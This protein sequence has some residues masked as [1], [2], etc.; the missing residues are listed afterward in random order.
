MGTHPETMLE[1]IDAA[2][3]RLLRTVRGFTDDDVRRPSLLPGWTRGHVLAHLTGGAGALGT[4][5][6]N[7][8]TGGVEPAYAS[9]EA[10]DAAIEDGSGRPADR[11]LTDVASSAQRFRDEVLTMPGPAWERHVYA[12]GGK[13]IL[14]VE[15]L[16]RRLVE[17]ELHHVDLDA[18]YGPEDWPQA[19]AQLDLAEPMRTQRA[20]RVAWRTAPTPQAPG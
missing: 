9:Q 4:L 11:L 8:R 17:L 10:R 15:L 20:D 19:F 18:G 13:Q 6:R 2:T 12:P 16:E 1:Q 7:A 14:A 5:L 3:E